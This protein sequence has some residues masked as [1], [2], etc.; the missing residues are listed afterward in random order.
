MLALNLYSEAINLK[1]STIYSKK[2]LLEAER[3]NC[4]VERLADETIAFKLLPSKLEARKICRQALVNSS[5]AS[6]LQILTGSS[7]KTKRITY[8]ELSPKTTCS[9]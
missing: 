1:D 3:Y 5:V 2:D 9:D 7:L 8:M 4:S 6:R